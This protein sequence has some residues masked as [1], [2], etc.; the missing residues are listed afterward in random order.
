MPNYTYI[1]LFGRFKLLLMI[2]YIFELFFS[3][4]HTWCG[5]LDYII[6][7]SCPSL[8]SQQGLQVFELK[9]DIRYNL[10]KISEM[11]TNYRRT[12]IWLIH[13]VKSLGDQRY[14]GKLILAMEGITNYIDPTLPGVQIEYQG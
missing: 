5:I 1:K 9:A 4:Y 13:L 6:P 7:C 12:G 2:K 8:I 3:I 11:E 14:F 10:C